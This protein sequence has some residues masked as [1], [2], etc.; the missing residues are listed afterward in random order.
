MT[1]WI[2]K[3]VLGP[4]L[5]VLFRVKVEGIDN[6]PSE[7][8]LILT[9]NHNSFMDSIFLPLVVKRRVTF[10]AKAEYFD[11]WKTRW[12]FSAMGQIPIR[13]EGGSASAGALLAAEEVLAGGGVFGIY[14]EGTRSPD[15]RL[16][17]GHTGF[18]R[19]AA[20]RDCPVVP[21]AMLGT[22]DVQ[23]IDSKIPRLRPV[24]VKFG[25]QMRVPHN[26]SDPRVLR[27]FTDEVMF[28]IVSL[29]GQAYVDQ[30]ATRAKSSA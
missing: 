20:K 28:E 3:I 27:S 4:L 13:R 1:Y 29:S 8:P 14:P 5:R 18:A 24:T 11:S 22:R 16:Y 25:K 21:V 6:L 30:Y 19:L 26:A 17:R 12:F 9:P 15:G 2:T 23:P 10:V 7:G